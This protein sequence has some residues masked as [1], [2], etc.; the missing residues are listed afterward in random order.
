MILSVENGS[1]GYN[2]DRKVFSNI[3]FS[4][5]SGEL[6]AILGPNGAG[7]TTLLRCLMGF[8]PW[9]CGKSTL[10][11]KDIRKITPREL[12]SK[13]SYVP[14]AKSTVCSYS[15]KDM[16]MLGRGSNFGF[17]ENPSRDDELAVEKIIED[18]NIGFLKDK[19]CSEIS[20][21]ELQMVLIAKA[22]ASNPEVLI[23]DEPESN[24]DFKNQ[25]LVLD[26]ISRL[27]A[28]GMACI[29]NTHYPAHALQR[30]SKALILDKAG[31]AL[32]GDTLSVITEDNIQSAF[33]VKAVIGE[34]ETQQNIMK[35]VIPLAVTESDAMSLSTKF[36]PAEQLAVLSIAAK[37]ESASAINSLLHEYHKYIV[38]R[39]GMP[40]KKYD[41]NIINLTLDGPKSELE[42]L[43]ARL[44]ALPDVSVKTVY[45]GKDD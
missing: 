5:K 3:D 28:G 33:D 36:D 17:F 1:F 43:T 29:F 8:L 14:Q 45:V 4:V 31:N 2:H 21:G 19:L 38:G 24:L 44:Y 20:G 15:V 25:L 16:I 7:K 10:D 6:L 30:A 27:V 32:F 22:L 34:V 18:M 23:L 26:T 12:W 41:V 40:Y 11:G 37:R 9:S 42:N 39:M 35:D 13:V